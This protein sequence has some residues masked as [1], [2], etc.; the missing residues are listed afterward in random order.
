M[1]RRNLLN[2]LNGEELL[3]T[4]QRG[5]YKLVFEYDTKEEL[6]EYLK[7]AEASYAQIQKTTKRY[8]ITQKII[9]K[10]EENPKV[11]D[12]YNFYDLET[13]FIVAK[14]KLEKVSKSTYKAYE[15]TFTKLKEFFKYEQI[16][17]L[18]I[19]DY[20]RFRDYLLKSGLVS[21]T[22]NNHIA[23]VKMFI[24]WGADRKLFE[25][26]ADGVEMLAESKPK[27]EKV[28]YTDTEI[29][30]ILAFDYEQCFKDIY[31]IATHTG[32][33]ISEIH[34]LKKEN[35]KQDKETGIYYFDIAKS[36]T[37]S[38]VRQ[39]PI[40]K[41][42]LKRVLEIDFPIL[43]DKTDDAAQKVVLRQLYRIVQKSNGKT[44]HTF[45]AKFIEK[46]IKEYPRDILAIQEIVGH[47]K[48]DSK[49]LTIDTYGKGFQLDYKKMITDSVS[50]G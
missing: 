12:S 4:F 2:L 47:S 6:E 48:E 30:E 3:F 7:L 38:G 36:K 20:E 49:K 46:C 41:N 1:K 8:E 13:K 35:I 22:V 27:I 19:E 23:Y 37:N 21:K 25:N 28:N 40:H 33:R 39:V 24:K 10:E 26:N 32:M 29:K 14:K 15:A 42:I 45:R 17:K 50:Y 34:A 16:N 5:D 44:F 43:K 9:E 31:L 18:E 11:K